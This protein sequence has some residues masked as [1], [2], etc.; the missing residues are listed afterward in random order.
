MTHVISTAWRRYLDEE[1]ICTT[2]GNKKFLE[3]GSG[4]RRTFSDL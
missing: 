1:D 3:L 4:I 2:M